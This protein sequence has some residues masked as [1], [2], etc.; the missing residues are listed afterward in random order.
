VRLWR[1]LW[2]G[3]R[4]VELEVGDGSIVV[5]DV[6]A[7]VV[8]PTVDAAFCRLAIAVQSETLTEWIGQTVTAALQS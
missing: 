2:E 1:H 5:D 6:G 4:T 3:E 7:F 8:S